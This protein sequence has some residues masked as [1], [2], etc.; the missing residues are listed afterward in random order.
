MRDIAAKRWQDRVITNSC[1]LR[2]F[3]YRLQLRSV[4]VALLAL[5]PAFL[6]AGACTGD[7]SRA[8]GET[9]R[10]ATAGAPSEF[11]NLARSE[12]VLLGRANGD[13]TACFWLGNISDGR[14]LSWPY[15]YSARA[16][17]LAVYNDAGDRVAAVGQR[18]T[19][20]GGLMADSVHS[21]TG[22]PGFT[23]FWGV[24]KVVSATT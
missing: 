15:G 1:W 17:P 18:V 4:R 14:A 24:G 22:C 10:I 5:A 20:A 3:N 8:G 19:M 7:T 13:G 21:I 23:Q 12:G 9:Y 11:I 16:N 6:F 2:R